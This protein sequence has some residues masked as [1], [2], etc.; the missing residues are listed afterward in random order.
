MALIVMPSLL[1]K[2]PWARIRARCEA[3]FFIVLSKSVRCCSVRGRTYLT[4][5]ALKIGVTC[6]IA[7]EL[8]REILYQKTFGRALI[9]PVDDLRR[10]L[11]PSPAAF[12]KQAQDLLQTHL[13]VQRRQ[14]RRHEGPQ[15][16]LQQQR[17]NRHNRLLTEG[18]IGPLP[19][20]A[21]GRGL[22]RAFGVLRFGLLELLFQ[23]HQGALAL[24]QAF[25][26]PFGL[27][28]DHLGLLY[29]DGLG[30]LVYPLVGRLQR[31]SELLCLAL[32]M[33]VGTDDSLATIVDIE[34][35]VVDHAL[36][37]MLL[38]LVALAVHPWPRAHL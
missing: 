3:S 25:V 11:H 9:D 10:R 16:I 21:Q 1:S 29:L 38:H 6:H 2:R 30:L 34:C 28:L 15:H 4:L 14:Q 31:L 24:L 20:G 19:G 18:T 8:S 32:M 27:R 7:L 36:E 23:G 17:A 12:K 26:M 22:L 35:P 5:I 37:A 13:G 33:P